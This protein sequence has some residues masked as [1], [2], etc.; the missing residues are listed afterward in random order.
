M[1][2]VVDSVTRQWVDGA[3]KSGQ[4][5]GPG[6][7]SGTFAAGVYSI[8]ESIDSFVTDT[9][10]HAPED[11]K[12]RRQSIHIRD[13]KLILL[14]TKVKKLIEIWEKSNTF[15]ADKVAIF[16]EKLNAPSAKS[17]SSS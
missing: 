16:K 3:K 17:M 14:Q 11:Q 1:L 13:A 15:P 4:T 5:I 2:Y 12:V 9:I 8:I 7:A 10:K 6:A